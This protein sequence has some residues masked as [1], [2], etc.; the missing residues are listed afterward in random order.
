MPRPGLGGEEEGDVPRDVQQPHR[1]GDLVAAGIR[2]PASVPACEDELERRLDG[3]AEL[4]PPCESLRHL[5]HRRKRLTRSRAGVGDRLRNERLAHLLRAARP[6]VRPVEREHLLGVGRV[7]EEERRSV[8]DVVVIQ[9][10]RLVPVRRA[11]GGVEERDVVGV[12]ELLRRRSGEL[13]ETDCEHRGA[14]RMLE[15]LPGAEVG[16]ERDRADGLGR[17]NRLLDVRQ[18]ST[19]SG[20][21]CRHVA[22][23]RSVG[24]SG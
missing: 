22:I 18:C 21:G 8:R 12:D 14:Q 20:V 3:R 15:R 7:D 5:A 6:D 16:R 13:A 10:D 24:S 19:S 4:E 9:L 17:A 1:Q 23:L 11:A 2:E